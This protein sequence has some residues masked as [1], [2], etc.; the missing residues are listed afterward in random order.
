MREQERTF[1]A[2]K[3]DSVKRGLIG[4]IIQRFEDKGFKIIGLKMLNVT[5]EQAKKH[6]E[7]HIGKPFYPSLV[8]YITSG[9]IVAMV[10]Q[11]FDAVASVRQIVGTTNPLNADVG[12]IRGDFAQLM[13]YNIIH[14]SDAVESGQR[15]IGLYFK[16]EELC[17]N[18]ETVT[19]AIV[20]EQEQ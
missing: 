18:W 2:L 7:E 3:P 16:P 4:K 20:N 13:K 12:T 19:E 10:V 17:D 1:V 11:G 15:E 9:P 5:E 8:K 14:A 6:Y